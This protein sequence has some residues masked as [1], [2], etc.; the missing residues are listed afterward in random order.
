MIFYL[1]GVNYKDIPYNIQEKILR[2]QGRIAD[3]W[4]VSAS[5]RAAILKTCNRFEIYAAADVISGYLKDVM[6]FKK[7]FGGLFEKGY[8]KAGG[9][10]VFFHGLRLAAG[11][12]SQ[13]KGELQIL[14]QIRSWLQQEPFPRELR[15][16]WQ[17]ILPLAE[18]IR[19]ETGFTKEEYNIASIVFEDLLWNIKEVRE[20]KVVVVGTGKV[21]ELFAEFKPSDI[22]LYFA[23]HKNYQ[24]ARYLANRAKGKA[25]FLKDIK[26]ILKE[27]D[28]FVSATT[29]PHIILRKADLV[30][31]AANRSRPLYIYDLAVPRDVDPE[32]ETLQGV[33]L[34]S[35]NTSDELFRRHSARVERDFLW[36]QYLAQKTAEEKREEFDNHDLKGWDT[37]EQIGYQA[38]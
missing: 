31:A 21:A 3:F 35:P 30:E 37:S 28:A 15:D 11:L 24:R 34:K 25:L 22:G 20:K 14:K 19:R 5:S 2:E 27:A 38:G 32:A 16:F 4:N 23:S 7:L 26:G 1:I 17:G 9:E 18:D 33:V 6:C 8:V 36:A 10:N 13:L 29:S 12:D